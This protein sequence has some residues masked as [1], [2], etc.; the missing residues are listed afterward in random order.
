MADAATKVEE[1]IG[2]YNASVNKLFENGNEIDAMWEGD[3]N[4][5]FASLLGND[6]ERFDAFTR[7]LLSFAEVLRRNAAIYSK[8]ESD[9]LDLLN[10]NK[11][12]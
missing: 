11:A 4:K 2:R 5:K 3:A 12:R 9:V 8:A 7:M 10:S 1:I 6:R